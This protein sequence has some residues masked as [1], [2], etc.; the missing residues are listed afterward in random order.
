MP[1][2]DSQWE[3]S[4][5][6]FRRDTARQAWWAIL[7][8]LFTTLLVGVFSDSGAV[9]VSQFGPIIASMM[10]APVSIVLGYLGVSAWE[11]RGSQPRLGGGYDRSYGPSTRAYDPEDYDGS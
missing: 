2:L 8:V 7:F 1:R 6:K 4:R 10:V 3:L 11:A 9:R 5:R